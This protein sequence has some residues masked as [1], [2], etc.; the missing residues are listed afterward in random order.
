MDIIP[1]VAVP[2]GL[3]AHLVILPIALLTGPPWL[4]PF[5]AYYG[6]GRFVGPRRTRKDSGERA[7]RT[8][9]GLGGRDIIAWNSKAS[10]RSRRQKKTADHLCRS[11]DRPHLIEQRP[12]GRRVQPVPPVAG[13]PTR[14]CRWSLGRPFQPTTG[15]ARQ[16]AVGVDRRRQPFHGQS[17]PEDQ[18]HRADRPPAPPRHPGQGP[19]Q[20]RDISVRQLAGHHCRRSDRLR[21]PGGPGHQVH[22]LRGALRRPRGRDTIHRPP[23]NQD[24]DQPALRRLQDRPSVLQ[25]HQSHRR[26]HRGAHANTRHQRQHP[27]NARANTNTNTGTRPG[28]GA[29]SG[30]RSRAGT[31]P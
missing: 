2:N 27:P 20:G 17:R 28:A 6:L 1:R 9:G 16:Q 11:A 13:S 26:T 25:D 23:R 8:G 12:A 7:R 24:R 4:C 19:D 10:D 3:L 5:R 15:G 22:G 31:R 18:G 21:I 29:R 14:H 30:A